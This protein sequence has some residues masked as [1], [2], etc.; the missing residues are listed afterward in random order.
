MAA[1][2]ERKDERFRQMLSAVYA[3]AMVFGSLSMST[4]FDELLCGFLTARSKGLVLF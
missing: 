1:V 2:P 3:L 4:R